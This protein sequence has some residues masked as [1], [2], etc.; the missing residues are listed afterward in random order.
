VCL[1]IKIVKGQVHLLYEWTRIRR[2]IRC[3]MML[4]S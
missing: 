1:L 4:V 2:K 3:K